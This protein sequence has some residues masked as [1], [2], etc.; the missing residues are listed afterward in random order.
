VAT[1]HTTYGLYPSQDPTQGPI[2]R[3]FNGSNE[4][5]VGLKAGLFQDIWTVINPNITPLQ[6][7]I[8]RGDAVLQRALSA[9]LKEPP[10]QQARSLSQLYQLRDIAIRELTQRFVS[11]PWAATF[12]LIVSPLVTWLWL[13][14]I[15]AALGGLIA[16]WPL[17]PPR[18][19]RA[20]APALDSGP[21]A[22]TP[23]V[24]AGELV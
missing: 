16:L 8:T 13:G 22:A 12:L 11:H 23:P 19:R 2:G 1:L 10:A 18:P 7:L 5:R 4:S 9:A 3:F 14:A 6:G 24:R 15:I 20:P 21:A 17:P